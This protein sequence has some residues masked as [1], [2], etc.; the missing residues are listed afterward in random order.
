MLKIAGNSM[1]VSEK[2]KNIVW[3]KGGGT[4]AICR[5]QLLV[6]YTE[7][8]DTHLLGEIAHIVAEQADGPRGDSPLTIEERNHETN[9]LLLCLNHHKVID[10]D[11][12]TYTVE[13]LNSIKAKHEQWVASRLSL[14]APWQT[15][16][17]NFYY[18]NVPRLNLLASSAGQLLDLSSY[19]EIVALHELGWGLNGLM[20]GFKHLLAQVELRAIEIGHAIEYGENARGLI[21]SFNQDFRTKNIRMPESVEGYKKA[22]TGDLKKD[23]HI[24]ADVGRFRVIVKIDPRWITTSTAFCEFRPSSGRGKFAGIGIINSIDSAGR[25]VSVTPYVIGLPSNP[26]LEAFYGQLR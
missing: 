13:S 6:G 3:I 7:S 4:C 19:G 1:P 11:P 20:A 21:V 2:T 5:Q 12:V 25:T 23:P 14:E 24:Y 9:L 10:D 17:H 22:I 18:I 8:S 26:F 16:L 15:K